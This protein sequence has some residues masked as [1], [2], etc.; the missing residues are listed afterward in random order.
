MHIIS[1]IL[2]IANKIDGKYSKIADKL[3]KFAANAFD[4]YVPQQ[5]LESGWKSI[6]GG[7]VDGE[8]GGFH[9]QMELTGNTQFDP[10]A[11]TEATKF[12]GELVNDLPD[13]EQWQ[14]THQ[15]TNPEQVYNILKIWQPFYLAGVQDIGQLQSVLGMSGP[16]DL[17]FA[18]QTPGSNFQYFDIT[19]QEIMEHERGH[20][21]GKKATEQEYLQRIN[22]G[23]DFLNTNGIGGGI[24]PRYKPWQFMQS[25]TGPEEY[26]PNLHIFERLMRENR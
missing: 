20:Q 5:Q 15:T 25:I 10:Q 22:Q 14:T 6:G 18:T 3:E 2:N 24:N 23:A 21:Y 26:G 4:I 16:I 9:T 11:I 8:L 13:F 17:Q 1:K 19:P 12:L 7:N